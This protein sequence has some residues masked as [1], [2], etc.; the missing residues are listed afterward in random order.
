MKIPLILHGY[1]RTLFVRL[2]SNGL[3]QAALAIGTAWLVKEIFDG[4]LTPEHPA[5]DM[6]VIALVTVSYT[7]LIQDLG[8]IRVQR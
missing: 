5:I 3:A 8:L 2:V 7:H 6:R 4:F 1:R